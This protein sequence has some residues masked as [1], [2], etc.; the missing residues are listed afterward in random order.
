MHC[1]R[2]QARKQGRKGPDSKEEQD[3]LLPPINTTGRSVDI[4]MGSRRDLYKVALPSWVCEAK[5]CTVR[6][7]LHY[8]INNT[9]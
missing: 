6:G 3:T 7:W 2:L 1:V 4:G 8:P 5:P 9:V